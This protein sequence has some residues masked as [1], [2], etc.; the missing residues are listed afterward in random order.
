[1]SHRLNNYIDYNFCV[2]EKSYTRNGL[3][4]RCGVLYNNTDVECDDY[5]EGGIK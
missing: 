4:E 2:S 3:N 1:V 5:L